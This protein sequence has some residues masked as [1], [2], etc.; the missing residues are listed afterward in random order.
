MH[1]ALFLILLA[2]LVKAESPDGIHRIDKSPQTT[3]HRR[4]HPRDAGHVC[5]ADMKLCPSSIGG[6]CCPEN[7][8]CGRESCY[9]TTRGPSTCG[10]KVG[11]YACA[12]VY[13]GDYP[14]SW[15]R[16]GHDAIKSTNMRQAAAAPTAT[17]VRE[18]P[19]ACLHPARHTPSTVHQAS[20]CVPRP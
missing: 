15:P 3:R 6:N 16:M 5:G 20:I 4:L 17:C 10:T 7:Y 14:F 2:S 18:Q 11:W 19:T 8:E 1:R 12:A 13:G 9:A